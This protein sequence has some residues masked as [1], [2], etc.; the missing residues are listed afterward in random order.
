MHVWYEGRV[1]HMPL[2]YDVEDYKKVRVIIDT[3]AACEA[4]DPYAIAHALM[5][6][7]MIV[8]GILA[9]HFGEPG[10]V[11]RSYDEI[12]TVIKLMNKDVPVYM[13]EEGVISG[14][15]MANISDASRFI[16]EEAL[17]EDSHKLFVLCQGAI[18]NVAVAIKSCPEIIGK[19]TVVWIGCQGIDTSRSDYHEFNAGNDVEAANFVLSSG[20]D[21]W[22]VPSDVYSTIRIGIPELQKRVYPCGDI[23]KHLFENLVNYNMT[24][25]AWWT[26]GESWSLGDSPAVAVVL[27]ENCGK[28]CYRHAPIVNED[29]TNS[30]DETRPMI[31]VYTYVDSRFLL[32]DFMCKLE[33]LYGDI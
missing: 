23:G 32:E 27:D 8:K 18:T 9:E 4:D 19:M 12:E 10:S 13:G 3:D 25:S 2:L 6:K 11:Q 16:I 5:S 15:D 22:L 14:V 31:R 33:L 29:T 26:A 24:K 7:K 20:V 30:Y 1:K 21:I 28:F 17:R